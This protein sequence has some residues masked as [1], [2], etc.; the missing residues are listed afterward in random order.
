MRAEM[1]WAC[2]SG[3]KRVSAATASL[4]ASVSPPESANGGHLCAGADMGDGA[5]GQQRAIR[6]VLHALEQGLA[7]ERVGYERA[8]IFA[9]ARI[10][11]TQGVG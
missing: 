7:D 9:T 11:K 3:E 5:G 1:P 4:A 8:Q 6:L 10:G 2:R